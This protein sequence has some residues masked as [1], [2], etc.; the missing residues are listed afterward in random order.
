MQDMRVFRRIMNC[1]KVKVRVAADSGVGP[2]RSVSVCSVPSSAFFIF[3][4]QAFLALSTGS[5]VRISFC[6]CILLSSFSSV[7]VLSGI[8]RLSSTLFFMLYY[9]LYYNVMHVCVCGRLQRF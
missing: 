9:F 5:L 3:S 7:V 1:I 2:L 6:L 4:C 8:V